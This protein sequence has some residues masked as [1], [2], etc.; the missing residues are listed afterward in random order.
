MSAIARVVLIL[1][2]ACAIV[3]P[4]VAGAQPSQ[5][6]PAE[7]DGTLFAHFG[8]E[9]WDD[10][11]GARIL[12]AVID[13]AA[14][15]A[16]AAVM[17]SADKSSNGTRENLERWATFMRAFDSA[18]IPYFAGVGN[19]DRQAKPGFP[20]GLDP[21]GDLSAYRT[22]F[23]A[24][25]YPFGDAPPVADERF[26]PRQRPADDPDGASSHYAVDVANT[27]WI[28]LDNSCF[29][30]SSC[31][32]FQNPAFP[33]SQGAS[34]Q[35]DF[36]GRSAAEAKAAGRKVFVVMH[37]PTQDPRPGHTQPTPSAH[38][39][40]EGSSP[41]NAMF[42]QE[43]AAAGVDAVF[44][45]HIK[46]QWT[47]TAREVPYFTDGGAGGEVYVGDG[48]RTGVDFG[49]WH[50]FRL[51]HVAPAG[52]VTTDVVPVFQPGSLQ[53]SG[54]P[55]ASVGGAVRYSA[56]GDQP[57]RDGAK[58][59][60]ELRAPDGE[61]PNRQNLPT[62]AYIWTSSDPSVLRPVASD[63]DDPRRD[64]ASQ[65]TSGNFTAACPGRASIAVTAGHASASIAVSVRAAAGAVLRR[66]R[67]G[68]PTLRR[69]RNRT[70][71]TLV[72]AQPARVRVRVRRGGRTIRTLV[73]ECVTTGVRPVVWD[74]LGR[75]KAARL[76]PYVLDVRV[77]SDRKDV[78]RRLRF[79]SRR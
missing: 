48:E 22:V 26:A 6:P 57:T 67:R 36:L 72:L 31:D 19:H 78:V 38:T 47:Y 39:M 24:R 33:D 66:L 62:P 30:L 54:P 25:P 44:L 60:L 52:T 73:N 37:M 5:W 28:F 35:F 65:T 23:A 43:A 64:P 77:R 27:R 13:E 2:G 3:A 9:H 14:R 41:D 45:G 63:R 70:L 7:R 71:A 10:P 56:A 61:R 11:D 69:G 74:G 49:Y 58:V 1:V 15:F 42:E 53:I 34:G 51:V 29:Q 76:G 46:G 12:P 79:R 50:G 75:T 4:S 8:E 32:P 16:P 18:G 17:T 21:T 55:S 68:A 40:G 59:K 20:G